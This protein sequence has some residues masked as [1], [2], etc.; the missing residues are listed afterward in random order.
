MEQKE[1]KITVP[2]GY[3][4]DTENSTFECIKFKKKALTYD[5][6][7]RTLFD[8][9]PVHFITKFGDI[10][11]AGECE[12][13]HLTDPNNAKTPEQLSRLLAINKLM[14]VAEYFNAQHAPSTE[15]V[16]T[17]VFSGITNGLIFVA[18]DWEHYD[19][20]GSVIFNSLND[21]EQA[22]EILGEGTI[23]LALGVI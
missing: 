22:V 21:A 19:Y 13:N 9:N 18:T 11:C 7:A 6:I 1:I 5:D 17:I 4:I 2:D 3:E 16:Y 23:K 8:G 10:E 20:C 15:Y 12:C 14:N